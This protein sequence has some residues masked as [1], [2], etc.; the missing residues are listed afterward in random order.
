M[1]VIAARVHKGRVEMACDS[2]VTRN[3]SRMR[4]IE[5]DK[6]LKVGKY[7]I[8]ASGNSSTLVVLQKFL[9]T[10]INP[11]EKFNSVFDFCM[12]FKNYCLELN[13]EKDMDFY[14]LIATPTNKLYAVWNWVPERIDNFVA[15]GSGRLE[16][17]VAMYLGHDV[18]KACEVACEL[19]DG[20]DFPIRV[21]DNL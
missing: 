18:Q 17:E 10:V 15:I 5:K 20:C 6:I 21:F 9:S 3:S 8:G 14:L 16:A 11:S 19:D 1:T 12:E 4:N 13:L 2:K 7:L